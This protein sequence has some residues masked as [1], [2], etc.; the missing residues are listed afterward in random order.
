VDRFGTADVFPDLY[1][2]HAKPRNSQ[3]IIVS[4][5]IDGP[6]PVPAINFAHAR[7]E[8]RHNFGVVTYCATKNASTQHSVSNS[9]TVGFKT[10]GESQK[11]FGPA[12]ISRCG[13]VGYVKAD[14]TTISTTEAKEQLAQPDSSAKK[15]NLIPA[16]TVCGARSRTSSG[17]FIGSSTPMASG[18]RPLR[19]GHENPLPRCASIPAPRSRHI[20]GN[21]NAWKIVFVVDHY[22]SVDGK[23]VCT[24]GA[25]ST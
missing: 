2:S 17:R 6:I 5:I 23:T 7:D 22:R 12:W 9:A 4:G 24:Y 10:S 21:A 13:G 15:Q 11:G 25:P 16:G 19:R 20:D 3:T 8:L 14:R 1:L 18:C